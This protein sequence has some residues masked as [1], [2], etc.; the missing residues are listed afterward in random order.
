MLKHVVE[1]N[2]KGCYEEINNGVK[3]I[4]VKTFPYK[5]NNW[6]RILNTASYAFKLNKLIPKLG[7]KKASFLSLIFLLYFFLIIS[8]Y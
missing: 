6:R 8:I 5:V 4:W 3:F 1:Y 7:T 2:N